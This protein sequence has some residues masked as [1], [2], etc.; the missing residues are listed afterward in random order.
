MPRTKGAVA[1][2]RRVKRVLK[3][4]IVTTKLPSTKSNVSGLFDMNRK[5]GYDYTLLKLNMNRFLPGRGSL[6]G[7]PD[8]WDN[9]AA[10]W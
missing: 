10:H 5:S 9:A 6:R 7:H 1:H 8:E 2:H 4:A 3:A